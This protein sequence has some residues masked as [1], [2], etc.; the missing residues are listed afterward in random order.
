MAEIVGFFVDEARSE[1]LTWTDIGTRLGVSRQAV[2]KRFIPT[3]TTRGEFWGRAT[4]ALR[5]T[6]ERAHLAAQARR[7]TY[8]GTGHLLLGLV[9]SP[10]DKAC[11]ALARCGAA[12]DTVRAAIDG[13]IGV[14]RGEPLPDETP[15]TALALRCLQHALRESLRTNSPAINNTHLALAVLTVSEGIAHHTLTNLGVNY[16]AL[17]AA[18][19]PTQ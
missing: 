19:T 5:E 2:Q 11:L 8:L 15:M 13:Q 17:R 16:E 3:E 9:G 10:E 12:P 1:G 14:P 18:I 4:P 6:A 7:K